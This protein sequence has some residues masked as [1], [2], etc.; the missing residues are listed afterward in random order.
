[1]SHPHL[2]QG[3]PLDTTNA[4]HVDYDD[5]T[6]FVEF[7]TDPAQGDDLAAVH[8]P[9]QQSATTS[10]LPQHLSPQASVSSSSHHR[11]QLDRLSGVQAV[12]RHRATT[13]ELPLRIPQ[14]PL[15]AVHGL[16]HPAFV[17]PETFELLDIIEALPISLRRARSLAA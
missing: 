4:P 13:V 6:A 1:M 8:G 3:K 14:P 2:A 15:G 10:Y 7:F 16:A 12:V 11:M 5:D 9:P 17:T